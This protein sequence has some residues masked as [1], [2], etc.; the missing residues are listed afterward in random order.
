[1]IVG[2]K[3]EVVNTQTKGVM[4][5][6]VWRWEAAWSVLGATRNRVWR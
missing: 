3:R 4:L 6:E 2:E 5:A 1:M